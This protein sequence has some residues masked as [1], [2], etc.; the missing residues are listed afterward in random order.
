M[1][2]HSYYGALSVSFTGAEL[3]L[4]RT[5]VT[6]TGKMHATPESGLGEES[7]SRVYRQCCLGP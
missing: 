3:I 4:S 1:Q 6:P 2:A 7:G 5:T